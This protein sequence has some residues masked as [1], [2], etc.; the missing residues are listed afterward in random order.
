MLRKFCVVIALGIAGLI[1]FFSA[2]RNHLAQTARPDYKNNN[3]V[4]CHSNLAEPLHVSAR[5]YEWQ[6]SRHQ[7]AGVGCEKCHGGDPAATDQKKAHEGV[8]SSSDARSRLSRNNQAATCG[9]CHKPVVNAFVQSRHYQRLRSVGLGPSCN[10]CHAHMAT[11]VIYSPQEVAN[12]CSDCHNTLDL[13]PPSP[14]I[15]RRA[16][17][18][19]VGLQRA[20]GVVNWATLL[21]GEGQRRGLHLTGE[22]NELRAAQQLLS[23]AKT[24]WHTF[25]IEETQKSADGAFQKGSK[26]KEDLRKKLFAE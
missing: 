20:N 26:V 3:C 22:Q 10:T 11:V 8:L 7:N 6:F 24:K 17:E 5:Y 9:S 16:G 2:P 13:Q 12:L 18:T 14:E 4:N 23:D 25:N 15:P 21:F 19:M 1:P